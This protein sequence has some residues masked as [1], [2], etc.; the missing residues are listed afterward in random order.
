[1]LA[2]GTI[3][4]GLVVHLRGSML[5]AAARDFLGDALWA[6]MIVWWVGAVAP[7]ARL[8]WRYGTA[9]AICALVEMSQALHT[10]MLDTVRATKVGALVLGS[11]FDPRDLVAYAFGV[12]FAALVQR[13]LLAPPKPL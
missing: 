11:G 1:M 12:G 2:L 5:G 9:Y 4:V 13:I 3:A 8:R 6:S 7:G 10:P